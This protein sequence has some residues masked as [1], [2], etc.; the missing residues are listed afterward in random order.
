[1][2]L[3]DLIKDPPPYLFLHNPSIACRKKQNWRT[4][5][6]ESSCVPA[7]ILNEVTKVSLSSA[8]KTNRLFRVQVQTISFCGG[9]GRG[10][11]TVTG[12]N[13]LICSPVCVYSEVRPTVFNYVDPQESVRG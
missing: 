6:F 12:R 2:E 8:S 10:G 13:R 7:R 3:V 1:M 9:V 11:L 5:T 4:V